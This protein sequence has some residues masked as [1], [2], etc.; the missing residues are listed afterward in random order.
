MATPRA[1]A[2]LIIEDDLPIR[3]ALKNAVSPQQSF[4]DFK[5]RVE[6]YLW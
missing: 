2:L 1:R 4:L 6:R 5:K 3:R